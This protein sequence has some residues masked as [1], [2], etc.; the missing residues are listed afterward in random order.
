MNIKK[1]I[2]VS[3]VITSLFLVSCSGNKQTTTNVGSAFIGGTNGVVVSFEPLSIMESGVYTIFDTDAFPMTIIVNNKGENS[4]EAGDIRLS[5]L[6]PAQS[7]FS[8]IPSWDK[9]NTLEIEKI[10]EFNPNGGEEL[11]SF[12]PNDD[13]RYLSEV[14]GYTDITWNLNYDYDYSTQ[15]IVSDVCFKGDITDD[16]VCK[17]QENKKISVSSAPITVISVEEETGGKGVIVLK[18]KIKNSGT[19][20]ST[21]EGQ[22]FDKRFSQV[23]YSIDN[24]SEWECKSGGREN[25]ARLIDGQA[26][27][28]CR[29]NNALGED[30]LYSK[31]VKLVLS[32]TYQDLIQETLRIKQSAE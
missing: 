11:I 7:D 13:A 2:I 23:S 10:S 20:D 32:Y 24:P 19:G 5:L 30:E 27:V 15:V 9:S 1:L 8:N 25:E 14:I 16:R 21:I 29:L 22:E 18:F 31:S 26:E 3:L 17:I 6:G 12:T 28:I 4:L